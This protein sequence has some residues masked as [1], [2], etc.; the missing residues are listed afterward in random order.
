[1]LTRCSILRAIGAK[2]RHRFRRLRDDVIDQMKDVVEVRRQMVDRIFQK[3]FAETERE[4]QLEQVFVQT[5]V[6]K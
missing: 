5:L 2:Q 6:G 4:Q 3:P 1:M